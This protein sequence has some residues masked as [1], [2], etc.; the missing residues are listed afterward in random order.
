M[1]NLTILCTNGRRQQIKVQP[2]TK[3]L[4]ILDE[5][6]KKQGLD[7]NEYD[8]IHHKKSLDVA[9]TFRLS[10]LPNNA[11]LELRKNETGPRQ[12]ADVTLSLQTDDGTRLEPLTFK[13]ETT[14]LLEVIETYLNNPATAVKCDSMK[15]VLDDLG[16]ACSN[17]YPAFSYLNE[18]IVG[19]Y[20][21]R[22]TTLKDLGLANGRVVVRFGLRQVETEQMGKMND[23]FRQKLEKKTKLNQIFESKIKDQKEEEE[24][25]AVATTTQQR[26]APEIAKRKDDLENFEQ[27][28]RSQQNNVPHVT[29]SNAI[30]KR[31][32]MFDTT[33]YEIIS[34]NEMVSLKLLNFILKE[35]IFSTK[36]IILLFSQ[37]RPNEFATFKFPEET[38][39]Q[40]LN[41]MNELAEI[42]RESKAPCERKALLIYAEQ[43]EFGPS[44]TA[45]A[46]AEAFKQAC[47]ED[48]VDEEFY[49]VTVDDLRF[50]MSDLK[51]YQNEDTPFM[52]K[53]MRELEQDRKAMRYTHIAVR[54]VFRN[55]Q[56]LQGLFRPKEPLSAL[57]AFVRENFAG[58]ENK[59]DD[60]D[61]H[62]FTTPPKVLLADDKNKNLFEA[63][64]CPAAL[65]HFKNKSER[66]PVFKSELT[67]DLKTMEEANEIV[68]CEVHGKIR[69]AD[70]HEGMNWLQK[71]QALA[72]NLF[73]RSGL[74]GKMGNLG[75]Q[76]SG[77]AKASGVGES[78]ED[79]SLAS[80]GGQR[81]SQSQSSDLNKKLEKFLKGVSKK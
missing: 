54:I 10:G 8:L 25:A 77:S 13:P 28:I 73:K 55:K 71:E 61:F 24:A 80:S 11:Q 44:V 26:S 21:I 27:S 32:R 66:A 33:D 49:K 12:F 58:G 2:N 16:A 68:Q 50:M 67:E 42:E 30:E 75:A 45:A 4:E 3:I 6:C 65:V 38:K 31:P 15:T 29:T 37:N 51:K 23:Q 52:T 40:D 48:R 79:S 63:E 39:G 9:L 46:K 69:D 74:M 81:G 57:Y 1:S 18:Q 22:N 60:L 72:Q 35:L 53:Q 41:K 59:A 36:K 14:T 43:E 78:G 64:L 7:P 5:V 47:D 56:T 20:Q 70:R 76:S 17:M 34:S 19:L 62:L